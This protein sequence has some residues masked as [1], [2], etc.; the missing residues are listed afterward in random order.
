MLELKNIH[1]VYEIGNK[2]KNTYLRVNALKGVS[3][4]FRKSEFVSILGQSGCGK[5]TLL[6]II[7]GLDKYTSGDLII[8]GKSTK[9]FKDKDWDTYRNH[10]IGF[11]FQSYNLIPH[12]TV[13]ENV[14]LALTLSG[15][16]KKERERRAIAVLKKVGLKEKIHSKPNQLSGGQ[17]QRV[18]IARALVNDP[19]IILADEPTGAL[20]SKTSIQIMD[21]L[22]EIS[23]DKLIVMVTHN[24]ELA[25]QY[26]TRIIQLSDGELIDDSNPIGENEN[27]DNEEKLISMTDD[28]SLSKS[29]LKKKN[30][31]K[32]MSFFTALALS[33]KN[34]LTKKARTILVSF[35]GSIGIIGIALVL[36]LSSGF[37]AYI[38]R[39]QEDTL[40]TYPITISSATI[41]YSAMLGVVMNN[42]DNDNK[43]SVP[44]KIYSNDV[45]VNMFKNILQGSKANDLKSF[46]KFLDNN[47]DI[48]KYVSGIQYTYP[49]KMNIYDQRNTEGEGLITTKLNPNDMY[50]DGIMAYF[51]E[52]VTRM[53][54]ENV[55]VENA[56]KQSLLESGYT[57]EQIIANDGQL[58][59]SSINALTKDQRKA[60]VDACPDETKLVIRNNLSAET[61]SAGVDALLEKLSASTDGSTTFMDLRSLKN[62]DLGLWT[63]MIDNPELLS[64]QYNVLTTLPGVNKDNL[65]ADLREDEV[66]LVVDKKGNLSD[67]ILYALGIKTDPKIEDI[68]KDLLDNPNGYKIDESSFDHSEVVGKTYPLLLDSDYYLPL[69]S[70][71]DIDNTSGKLVDIR[72]EC[73][74]GNLSK[75]KY[76]AYINQLLA[77]TS[78][79]L[80]I[81][82]IV[83]PKENASATSISGSIGYSPKLKEVLASKLN[84]AISQK[85]ISDRLQVV[86]LETPNSISL[87]CLDF[88]SKS[89]IEKII[90]QYNEGKAEEDQITYTDYIGLMMESVSTIINAISYVLIAFVSISLIVSSIM[91]GVITYISV[92]ERIKEIGVLRSIGASKKDVKR[93]F[94]AES[95]IIGTFAGVL[96]IAIT[97]LLNI[98]INIIIN[99]LAGIGSVAHLPVLGAV[100]LVAISM[101]LTFIAGLIP[102]QIAS[103]KD[104]VVALRTE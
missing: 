86:D 95:L 93:V 87:Y 61:I 54:V 30:K 60:I 6:N 83:Q 39:V 17:M 38:N 44:D 45:V 19:D 101:L 53:I 75:E 70:N 13:L 50:Y 52:Y 78:V 103:K 63:E 18:A 74:S 88:E 69:D 4:K 22:K 56:V 91:I 43:P 72:K 36:S 73:E 2:K 57:E 16:S 3:I 62:K 82:A 12:Q 8:N 37:Q 81:K 15:I 25:H 76:D 1:K 100:I 97:L 46:K 89:E 11:V 71:G 28:E 41:D 66:V 59:K 96:G 85:G 98:P 84:S 55:V 14:Q 104:P 32:K 27:L 49:I 99:S 34:L 92:L 7:G 33:F 29:E 94:T 9:E 90:A 48:K 35:A 24:P 23:N 40:S 67:Y 20:D 5:T 26:S 64:S 10:S 68:A 79:H 47:E 102:A 21:L 51:S 58:L 77:S 42:K 31:K 65:F 80:K